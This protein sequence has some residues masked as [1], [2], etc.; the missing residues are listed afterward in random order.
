MTTYSGGHEA[1]LGSTTQADRCIQF[2]PAPDDNPSHPSHPWSAWLSKLLFTKWE[3]M[4]ADRVPLRAKLSATIA[5]GSGMVFTEGDDSPLANVKEQTISA[6]TNLGLVAA[7]VFTV[8]VPLLVDASPGQF[9]NGYIYTSPEW[10]GKLYFCVCAVC[11]WNLALVILFGIGVIMIMNETTHERESRYLGDL[12][13]AEL[14]IPYN[15][16]VISFMLLLLLI[17]LWATISLLDMWDV[18]GDIASRGEVGRFYIIYAIVVGIIVSENLYMLYRASALTAKYYKARRT[19]SRTDDSRQRPDL[20]WYAD[21]SAKEVWELLKQYNQLEREHAYP[22]GF[23]EFVIFRM[24]PPGGGLSYLADKLVERL[25]DKWTTEHLD[26]KCEELTLPP[27]WRASIDPVGG[28]YY[29]NPSEQVTQWDPPPSAG[30]TRRI[31][32]HDQA[33]RRQV[34]EAFEGAS[35]RGVRP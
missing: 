8:V 34:G 16:M 26:A 17:A 29:H 19:I 2:K 3:G 9:T 32:E 24:R 20:S 5:L 10:V 33:G 11:A 31:D 14:M 4:D 23:K 7:L 12:A 1:L 18:D 28:R 13:G 30:P 25:F 6:T 35:P 27:G 22:D 15:L 21:P